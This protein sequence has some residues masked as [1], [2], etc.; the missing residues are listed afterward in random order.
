M[1]NRQRHTRPFPFPRLAG[2][3]RDGGALRL[4]PF[5]VDERDLSVD[6]AATARPLLVTEVLELCT[7]SDDRGARPDRGFFWD[8]T[9]GKRT[10]ALLAVAGGG[11]AA[12]P[13]VSV[14]LRCP[15]GGCGQEL[16]LELTRAEVA[17]LNDG[18]GD[19]EHAAVRCGDRELT[20]RRPRGRDQL[21]WLGEHFADEREATR[22]MLRTLASDEES[23]R[24]ACERAG[25]ELARAFDEAMDEFDP[26]VAFRLRVRCHLC[27]A[28]AEHEIDLEE[29]AFGRL[30]RAQQ[31]L[32][33]TVHRLASRY[34][35]DERQIFSVPHWRRS[36]YLALID[37]EAKR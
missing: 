2:S 8:L 33:A 27:G 28:E 17:E 22:A 14:V 30:R 20:F 4:R 36:Y 13:C 24:A 7:E 19:A 10:E 16:E 35:W 26:L 12:G 25:D 29:Y 5:G 31:E 21:A 18:H 11:G 32:L 23:L 3:P 15:A 6:F 1:Q 37:G 34:H 9:V